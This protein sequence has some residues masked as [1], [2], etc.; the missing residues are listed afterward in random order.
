MICS[1]FGFD[2][3]TEYHE[4]DFATFKDVSMAFS[5]L[6]GTVQKELMS[7]KDFEAI[8]TASILYANPKLSKEL[9]NAQDND[10]LFHVFA[11]NRGHCNWQN[12]RFLE[13]VVTAS[14]NYKLSSLIDQYKGVIFSKT[15]REVSGYLPGHQMNPKCYSTLQTC[16]I[17]KDPDNVTVKELKWMH[18][19]YF[20]NDIKLLN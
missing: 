16:F 14:G 8:K 6:F 3:S 11:E 15:L 5:T 1:Y 9:K 20:I 19:L 10:S 18:E 12:V 2:F 13:I 17:E 4:L 7:Y